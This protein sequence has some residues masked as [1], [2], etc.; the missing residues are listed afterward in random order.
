[1]KVHKVRV[2]HVYKESMMGKYGIRVVVRGYL[3]STTTSVQCNHC[4]G[5]KRDAEA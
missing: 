3:F 4:I 5:E 1:M 2:Q